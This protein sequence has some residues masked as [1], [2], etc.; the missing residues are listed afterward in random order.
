MLTR[1]ITARIRSLEV[2]LVNAVDRWWAESGGLRGDGARYTVDLAQLAIY[3]AERKHWSLYHTLAPALSEVIIDDPSSP[4]TRGMVA[5]R[6]RPDE[7]LDASGTTETLRV[8]E[9]RWKARAVHQ[10]PLSLLSQL[11]ESYGRHENVDQGI[12]FIRNYYN[13]SVGAFSPNSYAVDY[14]PDL[15]FQI[16][17]VIESGDLASKERE[18]GIELAARARTLS[19]RSAALLT[20]ALSQSGL[21]H[22]LIMPELSTLLPGLSTHFSSPNDIESLGNALTVAERCLVRCPLVAEKAHAFLHRQTRLYRLYFARTGQPASP[23]FGG[24]VEY[25]T[26]ARFACKVGDRALLKRFLPRLLSL[27]EGLLQARDEGRLYSASELLLT[28]SCLRRGRPP[29]VD[30]VNT[31]VEDAH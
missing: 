21:A 15:L 18:A 28:L 1:Q 20:D 3:A 23:E 30:K 17:E 31:S 19:T 12:W 29:P 25:A 16:A 13:L 6:W 9:A 14:D 5:W 8:I 26:A 22:Q 11:V 10:L 2:L 7:E 24:I 27:G 4:Y